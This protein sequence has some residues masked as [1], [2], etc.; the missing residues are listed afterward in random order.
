VIHHE[1]IQK[2]CVT[3]HVTVSLI[4]RFQVHIGLVLNALNNGWFVSFEGIN[5]V[6]RCGRLGPIDDAVSIDAET[7]P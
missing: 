4:T 2:A 7:N 1:V 3:Q 6:R 5:K